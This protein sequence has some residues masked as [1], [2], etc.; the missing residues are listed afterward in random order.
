MTKL[1]ISRRGLLKTGAYVGAG[2]AMPTIFTSS[3]SAF[4]NEPKGGT[5]T[6]RFQ[7]PSVRSL[8]G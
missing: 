5:V 2:L 3:A 4:T 1:T 6:P 8:C 7:R